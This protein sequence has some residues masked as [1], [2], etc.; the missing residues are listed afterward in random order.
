MH[1]GALGVDVGSIVVVVVPLVVVAGVVAV[2]VL[3]VG[4]ALC[5]VIAYFWNEN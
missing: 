4:V 1:T 5:N 2:I 3:F